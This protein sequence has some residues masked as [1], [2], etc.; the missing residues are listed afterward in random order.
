MSTPSTLALP[1]NVAVLTQK[2]FDADP[3]IRYMSL[4]DL[5]VVLD[6]NIAVTLQ[7]DYNQCAKVVDGFL[8]TLNDPNGEVQNLTVK[9]LGPFVLKTHPEILCPMLHKIANLTTDSTIDNAISALA[10]R[11]VV[12]ALPRPSPSAARTTAIQ[13]AYA[14]ISKVLIPR[15]VGYIVVPHGDSTRPDPPKGLLEVDLEKGSDSSFIDVLTEV[16]RCFGPMLQPAEVEALQKITSLLL[17]SDRTGTV[18]KKKAVA[19]LSM[20]AHYFS[21][22]LLSSVLSNVIQSLTNPHLTPTSRKLYINVLGSMARAIPQKFGPHL[23]TLAPFIFAALSQVELDE[24]MEA[25]GEEEERDPQADEVREAALVAMEGFVSFCGSDIQ[26]YNDECINATLRFLKYDP[27]V[28]ADDDNAMVGK[29]E[30]VDEENELEADEDF[31]EEGGADDEDDVSWKVR[32]CAAKTLHAIISVRGRDLLESAETYDRVALALIGRFK[33][34]E[35]NVRLEILQ[36]LAFLIRKTREEDGLHDVQLVDGLDNSLTL[37]PQDRKRRRGASD[38]TMPD[39]TKHLRLTGSTSPEFLSPSRTGPPANLAKV[40]PDIVRGVLKLFKTS[41]VP[42]K[43]ASIA[44]LK[45]LVITRRGGLTEFLDNLLGPLID[46]IKISGSDSRHSN[47]ASSVMSGYANGH[48]LQVEALQLMAEIGKAH[49]SKD[50]QPHISKIIPA[51]IEASQ[52]KTPKVACEALLTA[53]QLIKALTPPRVASASQKAS[54]Q[55]GL[56]HRML[57]ELTTSK[58]VDLSVRQQAIHVLGILS[59]R[60]LGSQGTKLMPAN[61]RMDS[62]E[63]LYDTSRNETTRYASIKAIDAIAATAAEQDT[64]ESKWFSKVCL[65][66][67]AQL[68]KADRSLRGASLV[69][70][71]TLIAGKSGNGGHGSLDASSSQQLTA[72]LVPLVTSNDLHLLGPSL[73]ILAAMVKHSSSNIVD[74]NFRKHICILVTSSTAAVVLDHLCALVRS[75]GE[76][77]VGQPLMQ[78]LLNSVG[79]D[80]SAAVIGKVIGNL[81]VSGGSNIGVKVDDFLNELQTAKDDRRKCL[82]L[83]VLGEVGLR[84]GPSSRL[85]PNLFLS[86]FASSADEVPL[87]AAISLGR[88][89]AGTGNVETY[90]PA[91][92][93]RIKQQPSEHYLALHSIKELLRHHETDS[94]VIPFTESLWKAVISASSVEDNRTIGAECLANLVVVNTRKFLPHLQVSFSRHRYLVALLI[95]IRVC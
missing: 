61:L 95:I 83:S 79:V 4:N 15:L 54:A 70:L 51:I 13:N 18:M 34:R 8:H 50:F 68:R 39:S 55:L 9:C 24:Q 81:L 67:G 10:V 6:G 59:G 86:Y 87:T 56:L 46:S 27:N 5:R 38:A 2:L 37:Q 77:G 89:S 47:G 92:L 1:H 30:E 45:D 93:S 33:E 11:A 53:E 85:S 82:A 94:E 21:V 65:E 62:F 43:Q 31:E 16:A 76:R 7:L 36:T 71:R 49:H 63:L 29:E 72:M 75:I 84:S 25:L 17:A 19:A 28:A 91:I 52:S 23:R 90:V 78:A 60:L 58:S 42:T 88:A 32:R 3:D 12:I 80:G 14:A 26:R 41:T 69:A 40:G 57:L 35:E 66:L 64:F 48:N 73:S 20:L 44:V 74:D 22:D